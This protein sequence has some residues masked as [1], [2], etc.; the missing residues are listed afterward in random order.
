MFPNPQIVILKFMYFSEGSRCAYLTSILFEISLFNG[1]VYKYLRL[2]REVRGYMKEI[3]LLAQKCVLPLRTAQFL[4]LLAFTDLLDAQYL[5]CEVKL[6]GLMKILGLESYCS[7]ESLKEPNLKIQNIEEILETEINDFD[8]FPQIVLDAPARERVT[9][10][11]LG[12]PNFKK[13]AFEIPEFIKHRDSCNCFICI[14]YEYQ[15]LVMD[16]IHIEALLNKFQNMSAQSQQFFNGGL[17]VYK[18]LHKKIKEYNPISIMGRRN[19]PFVFNRLHKNISNNYCTFLLDFT[20]FLVHKSAFKE[21]NEYIETIVKLMTNSKNLNIHFWNEVMLQKANIFIQTNMKDK[22]K[23]NAV[24]IKSP[25]NDLLNPVSTVLSITPDNKISNKKVILSNRNNQ[26]AEASKVKSVRKIKFD[27]SDSDDESVGTNKNLQL[28][29]NA[30][31]KLQTP[32]KTPA[33]LASKIKIYTPKTIKM[34]RT[35]CVSS[36]TSENILKTTTSKDKSE[37]TVNKQLQERTRL[38]TEKLKAEK[39][40]ALKDINQAGVQ[41]TAKPVS[42]KN[43]LEDLTDITASVESLT[44]TNSKTKSANTR[45]NKPSSTTEVKNEVLETKKTDREKK[46]SRIKEISSSSSASSTEP[47]SSTRKSSRNKKL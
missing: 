14:N 27:L 1:W 16:T 19:E 10:T 22:L 39:K 47:V 30:Y 18:K 46:Y 29:K 44:L 23:I 20:Y 41:K 5:D 15:K 6:T 11:E 8:C 17:L 31:F 38:L 40:T 3:T 42:C 28:N 21:A 2:P 37:H 26:V 25:E 9:C 35:R 13:K 24:M 45:L 43:L 4:S 33:P 7:I 36:S 12:S 32:A 34:K